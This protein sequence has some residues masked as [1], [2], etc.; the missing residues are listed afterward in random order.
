MKDKNCEKDSTQ[1]GKLQLYFVW[2][3]AAMSD[4]D[5][6]KKQLA[7]V[8]AALLLDERAAQLNSTEPGAVAYF[9]AMA[10]GATR[11]AEGTCV[12]LL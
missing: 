7:Q 9:N 10:V 4:L 6:S 8:E 11:N 3:F 12:Q 5:E 1:K 2:T